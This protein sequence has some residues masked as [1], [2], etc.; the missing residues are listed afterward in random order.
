MIGIILDYIIFNDH[1]IIS[2]VIRQ[3]QSIKIV[4][5][6]HTNILLLGILAKV[7]YTEQVRTCREASH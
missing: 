5:N 3:L 2:R 1:M 6:L 4:V 7:F